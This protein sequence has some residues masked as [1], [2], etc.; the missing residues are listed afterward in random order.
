V[1]NFVLGPCGS[2][3]TTYLIDMVDALFKTG[4]EKIMFLVPDQNTFQTEKKLLQH[5]VAKISN[6]IPVYGFSRLCEKYAKP[7]AL[8][9]KILDDSAKSVL[10]NI[11]LA[12]VKDSLEFYKTQASKPNFVDIML[13]VAKEYKKADLNSEVLREN[14]KKLSDEILA[15]KI[16]ET[17]LI[18]DCYN[19]II[20]Q[21]FV[22]SFDLLTLLKDYL[23][24]NPIFEGYTIVVDGFSGFTAQEYG[25]LRELLNQSE[26]FFCALTLEEHGDDDMFN[27]PAQTLKTLRA[28]SEDIGKP[29]ACKIWFDDVKSIKSEPILCLS[30]SIFRAK[31]EIFSAEANDICIVNCANIHKEIEFVTKRVKQI[32][33]S[34]EYEYSDIAIICRDVKP[35]L[36]I[37]NKELQKY[38]IP[39]FMDVPEMV[40]TKSLMR[41]VVALLNFIIHR[42]DIEYFFELIKSGVLP[43]EDEEIFF[44]EKYIT[45]WNITNSK[46]VKEFSEHPNGFCNKWSNEDVENLAKLE[47]MRKKIIEPIIEFEKYSKNN[48]VG[49]QIKNLHKLLANLGIESE[50]ANLKQESVNNSEI[51]AANEE[52]RLWNELVRIFENTYNL[53]G[54]YSIGIEQLKKILLCQFAEVS[55]KNIPE[56]INQVVVASAERTRIEKKKIVF[57]IG[58]ID[59]KFPRWPESSGLF[60]D[61][62]RVQLKNSGLPIYDGQEQ[63]Y[64]LELYFTYTAVSGASDKLYITTYGKNLDGSEN[65]AS[66]IIAE[67]MAILPN[68]KILN[69]D[70]TDINN[71]FSPEDAEKLYSKIKNNP[72]KTVDCAALEEYLRAIGKYDKFKYITL[73]NRHPERFLID[74]KQM[75]ENYLSDDI[76]L[77]ASRIES[78]NL[79]RFKYFLKYFLNIAETKKARIDTLESGSLIHYVLEEIFKQ[80]DLQNKN[81]E[82]IRFEINRIVDDYSEKRFGK[83]ILQ[84]EI[85]AY[86][87]WRVKE[88]L[89]NLIANIKKELQNSN[90]VPVDFELKIGDSTEDIPSYKVKMPNGNNLIIK[91]SIDRV[92]VFEHE[93]KKYVRVIDYKLGGKIFNLSDVFYGLNMQMLLYLYILKKNGKQHFNAEIIPSGILYMPSLSGSIN[94]E[95]GLS[96]ESL[97]KKQKLQ[98][99]MNGL[100]LSEPEIIEAMDVTNSGE[101][102][103]VSIAADGKIKNAGSTA[104]LA[105]FDSIFNKIDNI[106][107]DMNSSLLKGDFSAVP[108]KS[109][110]DRINACKYCEYDSVCLCKNNDKYKKI[111]NI[112]IDSLLNGQI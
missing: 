111:E 83:T 46:I 81:T 52:L 112:E 59:G 60:T 19:A 29:S 75:L 95:S 51:Q 58:A 63:L 30:K 6:Q 96:E 100:I 101:F 84:D 106:I 105:Q 76:A 108:A 88:S 91:G 49:Q 5:L 110:D 32:V 31:K 15:K 4:C 53:V 87:I 7:T 14:A 73:K 103:P 33:I 3:K 99:K 89:A 97:D 12:E 47:N 27:S 22:D 109:N 64:N 26:E 9:L 24:K 35:Y 90:F 62:E 18:Y 23:C 79:C 21:K 8:N 54:E 71:V 77:S 2:G 55:L 65:A 41:A 11:A 104:T 78:F 82:E 20:S 17:A 93:D 57:I 66:P 1:L 61:K 92:D 25:V 86:E 68:V 36:G 37:L 94:I 50:I 67:T 13:E 70:D 34:E 69:Y 74:N 85:F 44:L 39:F 102:I 28:I 42:Y 98:F 45:V 80:G 56:S 10:M 40:Q 43:F 107:F 38:K 72:L 48:S 16:N